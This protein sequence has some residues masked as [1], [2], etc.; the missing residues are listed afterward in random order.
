MT[1]LYLCLL[2]FYTYQRELDQHH[3]GGSYPSLRS[4]DNWDQ[5]PRIHLSTISMPSPQG[6]V[7]VERAAH[8]NQNY[9]RIN[10]FFSRQCMP[11]IFP[12]FMSSLREKANLPGNDQVPNNDFMVH[13]NGNEY[14]VTIGA[15]GSVA[16]R[17]QYGRNVGAF[18]EN[19]TE[20][21]ELSWKIVNRWRT[22]LD[23][24]EPVIKSM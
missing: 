24:I 13:I 6:T 8:F 21:R 19:S 10:Y 5:T 15:T 23:D 17:L 16:C 12:A 7:Q 22:M 14:Q 11:H 9:A 18:D 2:T 1:P 20:T 4:V 3:Q